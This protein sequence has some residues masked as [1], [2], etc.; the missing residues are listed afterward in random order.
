M[1]RGHLECKVASLVEESG[2]TRVVLNKGAEDGVVLGAT[3]VV[4]SYGPEIIDPETKRNL[5]RLENIRGKGRVIHLQDSISTIETYEREEGSTISGTIAGLMSEGREAGSPLGSELRRFVNVRV[6]DLARKVP[7]HKVSP[8][9]PD[10]GRLPPYS[11]RFV[12]AE[13]E[14]IW[15]IKELEAYAART[16]HSAKTLKGLYDLCEDYPKNIDAVLAKVAAVVVMN[17]AE[18]KAEVKRAYKLAKDDNA[19]AEV[20]WRWSVVELKMKPRD[21][22]AAA[23]LINKALKLRAGDP[24]YLMQNGLVSWYRS[25]GAQEDNQRV[26][27]LKMAIAHTESALQACGTDEDI[28]VV[29]RIKNNLAYYRVEA[30]PRNTETIQGSIDLCRGLELV[31]PGNAHWLDT[32]GFVN[33]R[34]YAVT[35]DIGAYVR[36]QSYLTRAVE[37]APNNKFMLDHLREL[38]QLRNRKESLPDNEAP[39]LRSGG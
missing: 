16:G 21:L 33:L 23:D 7:M 39:P 9:T 4:F 27:F 14:V 35:G 30:N 18:A 15:R 36:A 6:G 31:G 19:R 37:I 13:K 3:F 32:L 20:Y 8:L 29:S 22:D 12:S 28:L 24:R 5:G 25:R 38:E 11:P 34:M 10:S 26:E 2:D 1:I 17:P